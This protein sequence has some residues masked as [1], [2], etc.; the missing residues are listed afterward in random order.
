MT[1][2][3]FSATGR[4]VA[5]LGSIDETMTGEPGRVYLDALWLSFSSRD[6]QFWTVIGNAD[7]V[8]PDREPI[9][10]RLYD[11]ALSEGYRLAEQA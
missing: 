11:F 1:F 3:Q 7:F 6:G 8:S 9:E 5:D 4:D 10:R 2:E